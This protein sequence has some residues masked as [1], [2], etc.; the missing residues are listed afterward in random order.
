[1]ASALEAE[2]QSLFL[3]Y[4]ESTESA[5]GVK[6]EEFFGMILSFSTSLQVSTGQTETTAPIHT[7][8]EICA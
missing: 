6:A 7:T 4:G 1:M 2:L 8:T 3:Y 5:E